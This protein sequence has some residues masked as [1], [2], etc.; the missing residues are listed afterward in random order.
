LGGL[1]GEYGQ[2]PFLGPLGKGPWGLNLGK[3]FGEFLEVSPKGKP[4]GAP[5]LGVF[6]PKFFKRGFPKGALWDRGGLK[7]LQKKPPEVFSPKE[8]GGGGVLMGA[9]QKPPGGALF[10]GEEHTKPP[11]ERPPPSPQKKKI[12]ALSLIAD[13]TTTPR[14]TS[15]TTGETTPPLYKVRRTA[16]HPYTKRGPS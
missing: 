4:F 6:S 3:K 8:G 5:L 1:W 9:H 15:T 13:P 12:S 14:G 10:F 11:R 16:P 7:P 2:K